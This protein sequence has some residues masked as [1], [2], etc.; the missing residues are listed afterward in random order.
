MKILAVVLTYVAFG[1]TLLFA[2]EKSD[3]LVMKNGDRLTCEIKA[4]DA[5]VLYASFDYIEGT[6]S[7][8][9]SK[10]DRLESKQL[11][12]VKTEDGSAYTGT[13]STAESGSSRPVEIEV[14]ESAEAIVALEQKRIVAID[15]TSD[16]FWQRFNGNFNSGLIYSRGNQSTQYTLGV[17][18]LYP[19]ERWSAGGAFTSTLSG[20][21]GAPTS[22]RNDGSLY[23]RRTLRW[24]SW[25]YTGSASLLQSSEQSIDLQSNLGG[26]IGHYLKNTNRAKIALIGGW[27][28]RTRVMRK[29]KPT[30]TARTPLP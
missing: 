14:A 3:V 5:G 15:Q 26:G 30:R 12:L 29:R 27:P 22:T 25:F 9:W 1:A 6:T 2:R 10:V 19:R 8:D 24:S 23:L 20:S 16:R 13:L 28:T 17:Q 7:V 21:T 18:A 11:F 4:L